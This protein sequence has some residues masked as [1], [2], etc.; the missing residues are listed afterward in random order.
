MTWQPVDEFLFIM[1]PP[2]KAAPHEETFSKNNF[3]IVQLGREN[4]AT[5]FCVGPVG[6][7]S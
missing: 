5:L 2:C 3:S 1:F 4:R 7:V 6:M